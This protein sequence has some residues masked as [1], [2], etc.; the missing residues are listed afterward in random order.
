MS[1]P[2]DTSSLGQRL[3]EELAR[4]QAEAFLPNLQRWFRFAG[5]QPGEAVELQALGVEQRGWETTCFA[6]ARSAEA[7]AIL[8]A[9]MQSDAT[10]VYVIANQ[11]NPAV[12]SRATG[13]EWHRAKKGGSTT[14]ADIQARR[15]IFIDL[16]ARRPRGTSATDDEVAATHAVGVSV[17]ALLAGIVGAAALAFAH[18]G[19]GRQI[20]IAVDDE[21]EGPELSSLVRGILTTL[22]TLFS[23]ERVHIDP[24]VSDPKRL[25]PAFGSMKRKGAEGVKERP[26]RRTAFVCCEQVKRLGLDELRALLQQLKERVPPGD[27]QDSGAPATEPRRKEPPQKAK[28]PAAG[29]GHPAPDHRGGSAFARA[30][31]VSIQHILEWKQLMNGGHPVCPGCREADNGVAIV[32]NGLKCH[33]ARC[34]AKGAPTRPGFRTPVDVVA[35]ADGVVPSEAARRILEHFGYPPPRPRPDTD[36]DD[37]ADWMSGLAWTSPKNGEPSLIACLQNAVTI[38]KNVPEWEGV[39]GFDEFRCRVV[40]R[41]PPPWHR[42]DAPTTDELIGDWTDGDDARA[43]NWLSR[44]WELRL[45]TNV[46]HEAIEV[47][48]RGAS[49]HPV[50]EYFDTLTW[51]G[52]PRLDDMLSTHFGA[53]RTQYARKTVR[54][55]M[56]SAVARVYQPGCKVDHALVLEGGQGKRK[57]AGLRALSPSDSWYFDSDIPIGDKDAYQLLRGRLIV[58]FQELDSL[59]NKD[60][61]LI[62]KFI[63]GTTDIYRPSYGRNTVEI[64]RQCVFAGT[65][66]ESHYLRDTTGNR[67]FWPIAIGTIDVTRIVADRDQLWA[68]AYDAFH[69]GE[70]WWPETDEEVAMC[71]D[72]QA[73]RLEIDDWVSLIEGWF[74]TWEKRGLARDVVSS[75]QIL[76]EALGFEDKDGRVRPWSMTDQHR[77]AAILRSLGWERRNRG[78]ADDR[79]IR[80]WLYVRRAKPQPS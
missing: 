31:A 50:R 65:V 70:P 35:E 2:E 15:V 8:A 17:Y 10:G 67:R 11:L 73:Q 19:N 24:S 13:G 33:H 59:R 39:L 51:D 76:R 16:D 79:G 4:A 9:D 52:V 69:R 74:E 49:F 71:S 34:T 78:P 32:G 57:S 54:W 27:R 41:R 42:D 66:N 75:A 77:V 14:D 53:E 26:H 63:T 68:E 55:W 46:V 25:C 43:C 7:A 29:Q 61:A 44:K 21:P 37:G 48:G 80:P 3:D 58:E 47:V 30:N 22:D 45:G 38:L 56:I 6:F 12:A 28:A 64:R 1:V 72:Q 5:V 20:Y 40:K 23:N 36:R 62:K 18:S 60:V